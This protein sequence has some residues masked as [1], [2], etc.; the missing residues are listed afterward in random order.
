M[1]PRKVQDK[2]QAILH[3]TI[4]NF[5]ARGFWNTSTA[6]I[7]KGAGIADGTLFTYFSTKDDLITQVYLSIK[8]ELAAY[9]LVDLDSQASLYDKLAHIWSR[10][11]E[12]GIQNPAEFEVLQQ[13]NTSYPLS[14]SAKAQG[15][16]L[17]ETVQALASSSIARGEIRDLPVDYLAAVMD[18]LAV[19][20]VRF[21]EAAP[22][23]SINYQ[24]IGFEMF[25]KSVTG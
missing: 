5:S 19:M 21:I 14:E 23:T 9:L 11:I 15:N 25:W 8:K 6:L 13:I 18:S 3:S 4:E 17:F 2:Y 7:A 22:E 16:E 12:W 24:S 10:Y 20:T 1:S